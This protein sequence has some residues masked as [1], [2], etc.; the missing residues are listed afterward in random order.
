MKK[1]NILFLFFFLYTYFIYAEEWVSNK[2]QKLKFINRTSI[3]FKENSLADLGEK[4]TQW[5]SAD[6]IFSINTKGDAVCEIIV[7]PDNYDV[8]RSTEWIAWLYSWFYSNIKGKEQQY[9]FMD[10]GFLVTFR[11]KFSRGIIEQYAALRKSGY[12]KFYNDMHFISGQ[13]TADSKDIRDWYYPQ[14]NSIKKA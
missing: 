12:V 9:S 2:G 5:N 14:Y 10:L 6:I 4:I 13:Y 1:Q 7:V 8:L 11:L 3:E